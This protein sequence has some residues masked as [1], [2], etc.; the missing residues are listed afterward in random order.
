MAYK[1]SFIREG[2][3]EAL[4][5]KDTKKKAEICFPLKIQQAYSLCTSLNLERQDLVYEAVKYVLENDDKMF[6]GFYRKNINEIT[7]LEGDPIG[8]G[9]TPLASAISGNNKPLYELLIAHGADTNLSVQ[10]QLTS[11]S[12]FGESKVIDK[13]PLIFI[14]AESGSLEILRDLIDNRNGK[15][16]LN[17]VTNAKNDIL[18]ILVARRP[19]KYEEILDYLLEKGAKITVESNR[20]GVYGSSNS[21][22]ES[23]LRYDMKTFS[24]LLSY[25]QPL[26]LQATCKIDND[27]INYLESITRLKRAL[28]LEQKSSSSEMVTLN[29]MYVILEQAI[30]L[31]TTE[32]LHQTVN[33]NNPIK[34]TELLSNP[35][36]QRNNRERLLNK[37][38]T[39]KYAPIHYAA[40][41]G[42]KQIFDIL[43]QHGADL[44]LKTQEFHLEPQRELC[45]VLC[46]AIC[47]QHTDMALHIISL[48]KDKKI[49]NAK[50]NRNNR[51]IDVA[52]LK[53][54]LKVIQELVKLNI[55]IDESCSPDDKHANALHHALYDGHEEIVQ[56]AVRH[57]RHFQAKSTLGK[58]YEDMIVES[59]EVLK[60]NPDNLPHDQL[61]SKLAK[62]YRTA[63]IYH[64]GTQEKNNNVTVHYETKNIFSDKCPEPSKK[65]GAFS[66]MVTKFSGQKIK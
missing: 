25:A 1:Y 6:N 54:Q 35:Y 16:H 9:D 2:N 21:L 65:K 7:T 44:T 33:E 40:Q 4:I 41:N 63:D 50:S 19:K 52:G 48:D 56:F 8:T 47:G 17:Y 61:N 27:T 10:M 12:R 29:K 55:E 15:H 3:L 36:L 32:L 23:I 13:W 46:L 22:F 53:N 64:K 43:V 60:N 20:H 26:D 11:I 28:V 57:V 45:N 34:L 18:R 42:D 24:K 31:E 30:A 38:S 51:P 14:A 5:I 66:S 58:T 59:I 49:I 37:Y 39:Y 62:H